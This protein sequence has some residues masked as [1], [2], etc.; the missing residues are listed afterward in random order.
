VEN[1]LVAGR[2]ISGTQEAL[3]CVR[4]MGTCMAEEQGAGFAV[5]LSIRNGVEPRNLP[6]SIL[7]EELEKQGAVLRGT[8]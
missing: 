3:G 2:C 4:M 5:V 6:Y 1:L 8:K 7:G